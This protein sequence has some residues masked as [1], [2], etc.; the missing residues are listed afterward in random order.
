MNEPLPGP[1]QLF[2]SIFSSSNEVSQGFDFWSRYMNGGQ[3]PRTV[4]LSQSF[5]VP[6]IGLYGITWTLWNAR[7]GNDRAGNPHL[8]QPMI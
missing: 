3:F 7:R 6:P 8:R 1:V 5:G 2:F 4:E